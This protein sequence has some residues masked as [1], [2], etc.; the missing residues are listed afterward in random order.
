MSSVGISSMEEGFVRFGQ[1]SP[2]GFVSIIRLLSC[3]FMKQTIPDGISKA[4]GSRRKEN[5]VFH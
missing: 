5:A 1:E 4:S 3:V 2:A